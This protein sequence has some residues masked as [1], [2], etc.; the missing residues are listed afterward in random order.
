MP[1]TWLKLKEAQAATGIPKANFSWLVNHGKCRTKSVPGKQYQRMYCLEDLNAYL[2]EKTL[3]QQ[4]QDWL[5][6]RYPDGLPNQIP[7]AVVRMASERMFITE[8]TIH[9]AA[10]KLR[11]RLKNE[12]DRAAQANP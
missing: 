3:A 6:K 11:K 2:A 5:M 7:Q 9:Y 10:W 1:E 4:V 12:A 8:A